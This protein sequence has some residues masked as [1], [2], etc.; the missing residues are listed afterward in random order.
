MHD[1]MLGMN[2]DQEVTICCYYCDDTG[3]VTEKTPEDI[4]LI[5]TALHNTQYFTCLDE[6][7]ID[8]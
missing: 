4:K 6:E 1:E 2:G 5:K 3:K 8:R 7:Q